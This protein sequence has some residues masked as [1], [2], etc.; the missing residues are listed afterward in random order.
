M[1]GF[2]VAFGNLWN[3]SGGRSALARL[4]L[5]GAVW[6]LLGAYFLFNYLVV[7]SGH[8][9]PV[10]R[11]IGV[12]RTD[13]VLWLTVVLF[14]V[15]VLWSLPSLFSRKSAP[16]FGS[17]PVRRRQALVVFCLLFLC[18]TASSLPSVVQ[19]L[20]RDILPSLY[21]WLGLV[22][23]AQLIVLTIVLRFAERP[24]VPF[25]VLAGMAGFNIYA[26]LLVLIADLAT[27]SWGMF[28]VGATLFGFRLFGEGMIRFSHAALVLALVGVTPLVTL[29]FGSSGQPA[30]APLDAYH[31]VRF[32]ERP[33]I[34]VVAIDSLQP[35]L[36]IQKHLG[37]PRPAYADIVEERT[38]LRFENAF[39][40]QVP[41]KNSLNS[42]MRLDH[43]DFGPDVL[44]Y[45]AGRTAGPVSAVLR[46]NGYYIATGFSTLYFGDKGPHVDHYRP[47]GSETAS[48]S[49]LCALDSSNKL[50][51]FWFCPLM[52]SVSVDRE[53]AFA[54][55]PGE[56]IE[57]LQT[58]AAAHTAHPVFTFY[59][60]FKPINHT[61]KAF[62]Y[63]EPTMVEAY[64][65]QYRRAS[66]KAADII[67]QA[68]EA[69]RSHGRPSILIVFGDHGAF[70]SRRSTDQE[71]IVQDWHGILL[72]VVENDTRCTS[73]DLNHY[74]NRF[75]TPG[76]M[77]AGLFRCLSEDPDAFDHLARFDEALNFSEFL[78]E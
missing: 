9:D 70:L 34:H 30:K 38:T 7:S 13:Q 8:D 24:W 71:F 43:P 31:Q 16:D 76:R 45:F 72:A 25:A 73:Q 74:R 46:A 26:V 35:A 4:I 29:P 49:T 20:H 42:F 12:P 66:R 59:H 1:S 54:R 22:L 68:R 3:A 33:D 53:E 37:I 21:G 56:M 63:S 60:T 2:I 69:I 47:D 64:A 61:G 52:G 40:S 67:E 5:A 51:F 39:A 50:K 77:L 10:Y 36:L 62:D 23:A 27:W 41:T 48:N 75:I 18:A 44:G 17:T 58:R 19:T 6:S 32:G 65:D 28:A 14:N 55:W 57:L 15:A 11:L 78:Y